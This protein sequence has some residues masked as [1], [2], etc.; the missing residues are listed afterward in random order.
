MSKVKSLS[1]SSGNANIIFIWQNIEG[2]SI[3]KELRTYLGSIF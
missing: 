3:Y 1:H 2:K